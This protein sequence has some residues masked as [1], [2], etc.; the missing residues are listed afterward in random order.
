MNKF[1]QNHPKIQGLSRNKIIG[2]IF[3]AGVILII[4][5]LC[6]V[7]SSVTEQKP[8]SEDDLDAKYE[9]HDSNAM[10]NQIINIANDDKAKLTASAPPEAQEEGTY[11]TI[12]Q[13]SKD[14]Q[15]V[16]L[17]TDDADANTPANKYNQN[18]EVKK[19]DSYAAKSLMYSKPLFAGQSQVINN[20]PNTESVAVDNQ[21]SSNFNSYY[22]GPST[23]AMK[24]GSFGNSDFSNAANSSQDQNWQGEKKDFLDNG[25]DSSKDYLSSKLMMAQSR[26]EVKAGSVIPA[27]MISGLNSDL[28]GQIVAQVREN[29]YDSVTRQYLLIPQGAKLIGLYDSNIAYGQERVLVIWNRLIYPNGDS[30]N[31]KGMPGTDLE[32]YSGLHDIVDNKYWKLFGTSF[33]M[34][35]ITG[36]MQYSQNNTNANVQVGGLGITSNNPT[37]GQTMA[38]SLGQQLGQTG[39]SIAQ[40]NLNVQPTLIIRPSYPF[41]VMITA[42][43]ILKPYP[44]S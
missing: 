25:A 34:G 38:G 16:S 37:I 33:I 3:G 41:N 39:L 2:V 1:L 12:P 31:L 40:K 26:Y 29:V 35:V 18:L 15:I 36:A 24:S 22:S 10:I 7:F 8:S 32:G 4:L 42:D 30:I 6:G 5:M 44:K 21:S 11:A 14:T 28:P 43:I 23:K 9:H 20:M 19:Y 27:T 13:I 17:K